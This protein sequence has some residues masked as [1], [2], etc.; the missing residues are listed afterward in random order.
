MSGTLLRLILLLVS[1]ALNLSVIFAVKLDA[2]AYPR[3]DK[4]EIR[5]VRNLPEVK[6]REPG[7]LRPSEPFVRKSPRIEPRTLV[8]DASP[9]VTPTE[10][11]TE[12]VT[13]VHP[14]QEPGTGED[15]IGAGEDDEEPGDS[16]PAAGPSEEDITRALEGYR[17][18][19]YAS[20]ERNK[21]YPAIARKL[22]HEGEV[23][24]SFL[25]ARDGSLK[26]ASVSSSSGFFEL[27][28]AALEA[29]RAVGKFPAFPGLLQQENLRFAVRL[30]FELH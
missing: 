25:L 9:E 24:V 21:Q 18:L 23:A 20:I 2:K 4:L 10:G 7:K 17:R 30:A 19:V 16:Q 5:V 8:P 14:A 13:N 22:G 15:A 28:E 11:G 29:V 3:R 26:S 27:D 1:I 6:E 12:G